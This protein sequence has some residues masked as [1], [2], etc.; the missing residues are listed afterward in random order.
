MSFKELKLPS[1]AKINL[2]LK[3]LGK[4]QVDDYHEICTAFQTVSLHDELIFRQED[5]KITLACS[6]PD[7]PTDETNLIIKSLNLLRGKYKIDKGIKIHLQKKI[8]SP[9][10]LGG[11]SSNAAVAIIG[12]SAIWNLKINTDDLIKLGEKIGADVPYFFVGGTVLGKGR[13]TDLSMLRELKKNYV[14]IITPNIAVSTA[15][16]YSQLDF[17]RLT[18]K[19]DE[20]I[21]TICRN[22]SEQQLPAD[23]KP[24]ND[25]EKVIFEVEPEIREI[26]DKLFDL[27][28][29]TALMSGS[30]ASVFGI[31]DNE[32]K[33][34]KAFD[35][36]D[37]K[38]LKKFAV[39][40]ISRRE[41]RKFLEPCGI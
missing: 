19:D 38:N 17:P 3:I 2:F 40:T 14:L 31:F 6:D 34:Q 12:A 26:K 35:A 33:R 30:G 23:F 5:S 7:I 36:F 18:K 41:Y 22:L 25:F 28:A 13:G 8:P 10:G 32:E 4:R 24:S 37:D 15:K 21:L 9:G 39:Q 27:G 29:D 11:A 16:A 20:S 1:F